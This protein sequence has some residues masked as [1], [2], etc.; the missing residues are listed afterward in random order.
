MIAIFALV[1]GALVQIVK[2]ARVLFGLAERGSLPAAL[3]RVQ[4]RTGT[5][6]LATGLATAA[7]LLLALTL[8]LATLAETTSTITLVVF[9]LANLSLMLVKRRDPRPPEATVFPLWIPA[10]GFVVSLGFV[11]LEVWQRVGG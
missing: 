11:L 3:A 5:P 2:A 4:E 9:A 10:A 1:N 7:A 8:P 6:L